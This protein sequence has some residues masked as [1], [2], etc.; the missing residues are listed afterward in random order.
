MAQDQDKLMQ[1]LRNFQ[2]QYPKEAQMARVEIQRAIAEGGAPSPDEIEE[3]LDIAQNLQKST[4]QW[5]RLRPE[6]IA[7]GMP[8]ESLPPANASKQEI[9][10]IVG[11]LFLTVY[12]IGL[13]PDDQA[14]PTGQ[15]P[16]TPPKPQGL[17]QAG[18]PS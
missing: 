1:G 2:R 13:G 12:L 16:I 7:A 9:A 8:E 10:K 17:I 3:L 6:L 14:S 4:A 5:P 15:A 11:L 18:V